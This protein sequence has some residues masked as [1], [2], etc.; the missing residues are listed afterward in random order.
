[1]NDTLLAM[2]RKSAALTDRRPGEVAMV[3]SGRVR[4]FGPERS[5]GHGVGR[6]DIAQRFYTAKGVARTDPASL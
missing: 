4:G 2:E 1:M 3:L 5:A 6:S